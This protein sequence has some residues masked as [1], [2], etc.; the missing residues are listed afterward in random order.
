L[1]DIG[2]IEPYE[3]FLVALDSLLCQNDVPL[4]ST[5]RD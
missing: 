1:P 5:T 3:V 2:E 4:L